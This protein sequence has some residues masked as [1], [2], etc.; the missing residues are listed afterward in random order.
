LRGITA[1]H[2]EV[3]DGA[4]SS[5][6]GVTVRWRFGDPFAT[7]ALAETLAAHDDRIADPVEYLYDTREPRRTL[8]GR[9]A[10]AV[11]YGARL[12]RV[13]RLTSPAT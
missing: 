7:L 4:G 10:A 3:G 2:T 12:C 6:S 8:T 9:S 5:G 13:S 11:S 1:R